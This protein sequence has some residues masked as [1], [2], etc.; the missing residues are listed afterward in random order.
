MEALQ[1]A[2][3]KELDHLYD[4]KSKNIL[5]NQLI[6][7]AVD[8]ADVILSEEDVEAEVD[9]TF[10]TFSQRLEEED[11][12]LESYLQKTGLEYDSVREE[13]REEARN[14]LKTTLV[15]EEIAAQKNLFPTDEAIKEGLSDIAGAIQCSV[16]ELQE[17]YPMAANEIISS[18]RMEMAIE[19]LYQFADIKV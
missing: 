7:Q 18:L 1:K 13:L 15:L 4:I 6:K 17:K 10:Q 16:E 14:S 2:I 5:R 12:D 8:G 11:M 19:Y 9:L 3:L